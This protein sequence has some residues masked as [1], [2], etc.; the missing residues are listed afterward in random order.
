MH[1]LHTVPPAVLANAGKGR[2]R[3]STIVVGDFALRLHLAVQRPS[4]TNPKQSYMVL[5]SGH[6]PRVV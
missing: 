3:R 2:Q 6:I 5:R 4:Q 1:R